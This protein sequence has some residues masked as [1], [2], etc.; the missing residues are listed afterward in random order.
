MLSEESCLGIRVVMCCL[1]NYSQ[2]FLHQMIRKLKHEFWNNLFEEKSTNTLDIPRRLH[3][4]GDY[5]RVKFVT[6][7][8]K[9]VC[10]IVWYTIIGICSSAY[11]SYKQEIKR[12]CKI[13]P[14][15][16]K[17]VKSSEP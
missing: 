10:E 2:H 14:H 1:L 17:G 4:R 13:L 6:L 3:Q 11:L 12:G 9:D 15:R 16:N 8:E 7:Q 5:N